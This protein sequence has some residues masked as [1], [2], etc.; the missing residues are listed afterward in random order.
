MMNLLKKLLLA[1]LVFV[2]CLLSYF[3]GKSDGLAEQQDYQIRRFLTM[4]KLVLETM[5]SLEGSS[6]Q[7]KFTYLTQIGDELSLYKRLDA[8]FDKTVVKAYGDIELVLE[9]AEYLNSATCQ[10][11]KDLTK[12]RNSFGSPEFATTS[13]AVLEKYVSNGL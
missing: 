6:E 1:V 4:P 11:I 7:V 12:C 5:N 9:K 13:C 3:A 2:V 8:C 10:K